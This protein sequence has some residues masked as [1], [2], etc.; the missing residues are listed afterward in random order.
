MS[1]R[2]KIEKHEEPDGDFK[3][4]EEF[5]QKSLS[6]FFAHSSI[7]YDIDGLY[8]F[9]WE[10][11]K[12]L[13]THSG[14]IY[15]FEVK[16]SKADFKNDFKHKEEKHI[17]LEA[18]KTGGERHL[19]V[20]YETL[21]RVKKSGEAATQRW[22]ERHSNDAYYLIAGHKRPNY[23]YYAV[24]TGLIKEEDVPEYAGLVYIDRYMHI[25]IIKKAPCLHKEK[26]TDEDLN[27]GE[28]FYY[29]MVKWRNK[30]SNLKAIAEYWCK[31][32]YTELETKGQGMAYKE[33]ERLLE[34][35][36]KN[37]Q[38]LI[39][40]KSKSEETLHRDLYRQHMMVRLLTHELQKYNQDFNLWAFEEE[41][42]G[43]NNN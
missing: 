37:N 43:K 42:F 41:H 18:R 4:T 1:I 6:S 25:S 14:Y 24:P 21:E 9:G 7:K 2:R 31:Q 12:L 11:D 39:V 19:P 16:V 22:I 15:E 23:F 26:Y 30:S 8:V 35:T 3:F 10:S 27:L 17:I 40:Q 38:E 5:M 28:K 34:E 13:E 32:F 33:M 36:K 29:N 20:Y